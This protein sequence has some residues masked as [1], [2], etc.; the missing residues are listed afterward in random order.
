MRAFLSP[1]SIRGH[2]VTALLCG[3]MII[4]P[5]GCNGFQGSLSGVGGTTTTT[6]LF[7]F[8]MNT[9]TSS[10]L[11]GTLRLEDGNSVFVFGTRDS[12][13]NVADVQA[14]VLRNA[15]A[16]ESAVNL[17]GGLLSKAKGFDGSSLTITYDERST[18]H[19]RGHADIFFAGADPGEQNQTLAFDLDL[20]EL[21]SELAAQVK[22]A[23]GINI[24]T[25]PPPDPPGRVKLPDGM[26]TANADAIIVFAPFFVY[27]FATAGYLMVQFM[28]QFLQLMIQTYIFLAQAIIV[29]AFAPFILM[30]EIMRGCVGLPLT[31]TDIVVGLALNGV[32]VPRRPYL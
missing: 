23:T 26:K 12:S 25:A 29:V 14:A 21:L 32:T 9:D 11:L 5:A 28:G 1:Y 18:A 3:V 4:G 15:S 22:A 7:G 10:D 17:D 8:L 13:G 27:A 31:S 2:L 6:S 30:A 24:S 20:Q 19:V 16:E